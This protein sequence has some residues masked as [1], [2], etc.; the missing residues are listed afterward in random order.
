MQD[1]N[2][3]RKRNQFCVKRK[4]IKQKNSFV[5][6]NKVITK[7]DMSKSTSAHLLIELS[8]RQ[9]SRLESQSMFLTEMTA[10]SGKNK[11]V[12]YNNIQM[13]TNIVIRKRKGK[14]AG[15]NMQW[16]TPLL[17]NIKGGYMLI[18]AEKN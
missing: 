6:Y 15:R 8:S 1:I 18:V 17:S 11:N 12:G 2:K 10:L 9:W 16:K 3:M 5:T 7:L 13:G 4:D 14:S